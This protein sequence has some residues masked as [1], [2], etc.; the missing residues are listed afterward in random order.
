MTFFFSK[1]ENYL[2]YEL[3]RSP[4]TVEAYIRDL[5]EF[6]CWL[7]GGNFDIFIPQDVTT[8]DIRAWIGSMARRSSATTIR[9]KTQ[10][11]R[12]FF[13]WLV[14]TG[15]IA[16]NPASSVILAKIAKPL[17]EFVRESEM[18]KILAD[19]PHVPVSACSGPHELK[20]QALQ[21][22]NHLILNI[23][24]SIGIRQAELLLLNDSHISLTRMEA[25]V[26]GKRNKQRVVPIAPELAEEIKEWQTLRDRIYPDL[27]VPAPLLPGRSGNMSKPM[28]YKI[29]REGLAS[30]GSA[31]KSPHVLRHTFAT[32]MLNDG[33]NLDTVREMLG[34]ASLATTQIYTHLSFRELKKNYDTAHPRAGKTRK[35]LD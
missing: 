16:A 3:N 5:H 1:F 15:H 8:S 23:L 21:L 22:R 12:A 32:A 19:T 24:Y 34:H 7:S 30:T 13:R 20:E 6:A 10:S 2:K 26:T 31:K 33:A 11:L 17:P 14:K 4:L 29:V 25:K 27:P 9:R 35:G 28:L 18:E